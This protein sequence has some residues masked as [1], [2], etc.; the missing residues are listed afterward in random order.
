MKLNLSSEKF[1]EVIDQIEV[2][3]SYYNRL[4]QR[5]QY[6]VVASVSAIFVIFLFL[7][8]IG[9]AS[10]V[11]SVEKS[12]AKSHK[13]V[14]QIEKMATEVKSIRS[15]VENI[16]ATMRRTQVGFQLA[17]ELERIAKRF[18]ISIETLKDRS[19]QPND[20]YNEKQSTVTISGVDLR[21]L[22]HFLH[23]VENSK[24]L[25]R[26]T[27]LQI[28]PNFKDPSQLNAN[29]VVSTFQIKD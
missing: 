7:I 26:I 23:S 27:S 8:Y 13:N 25:M 22:I 24:Q 17:T 11:G 16:E 5:E 21:T 20:L 10:A 18:N 15:Q 1:S 9:V 29:F 14:E 3:K 6:I 28:K 4:S 19:G 12:I 2:M